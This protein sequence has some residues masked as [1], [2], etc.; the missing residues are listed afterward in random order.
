MAES[1]LSILK[2]VVAI[3]GAD[4][5]DCGIAVGVELGFCR[6]QKDVI[7]IGPFSLFDKR[8]IRPT[9]RED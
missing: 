8:W 3:Y 9:P 2:D 4:F 5:V 1:E 7:R 6:L